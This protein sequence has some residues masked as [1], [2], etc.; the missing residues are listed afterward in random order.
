VAISGINIFEMIE[1]LFQ[2]SR[3]V[4]LPDWAAVVV[5]LLVAFY[6]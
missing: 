3:F 5:V 6:M 4:G 2:P 1:I